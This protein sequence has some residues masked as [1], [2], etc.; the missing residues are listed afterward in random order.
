MTKRKPAKSKWSA[1]ARPDGSFDFEALTDEQKEAFYEE[2]EQIDGTVPGK[3][4]TAAQRRLHARARR[5]RPRNGKGAQIISLSIE[6]DLL[7]QAERLA[8]AQGLSRSD[9]FTRGLRAV[10]AIAGAA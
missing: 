10:L 7:R 5:G 6:K 2:C 8:K 1:F 9:L 3:P 4:L